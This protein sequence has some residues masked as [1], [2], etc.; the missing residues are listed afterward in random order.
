MEAINFYN[1][2]FPIVETVRPVKNFSVLHKVFF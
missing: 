2:Q 1:R